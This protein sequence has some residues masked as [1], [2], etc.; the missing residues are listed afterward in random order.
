[1]AWNCLSPLSGNAE[2]LQPQHLRVCCFAGTNALVSTVFLDS[3]S[4]DGNMTVNLIPRSL[5]ANINYGTQRNPESSSGRWQRAGMWWLAGSSHLTTLLSSLLFTPN[6]QAEQLE[7]VCSRAGTPAL[8][9][10]TIEPSCRMMCFWCTEKFYPSMGSKC[11]CMWICVI[12]ERRHLVHILNCAHPLQLYS[13]PTLS[14]L[15][16][17]DSKVCE[18]VWETYSVDDILQKRK[19]SEWLIVWMVLTKTPANH[20]TEI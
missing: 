11:I 9:T 13:T 18:E 1:M 8:L 19:C 14:V 5:A 6:T 15:C 4:T 3:R 10:K 17:F 12:F 20:T 7:G 16:T 2:Y